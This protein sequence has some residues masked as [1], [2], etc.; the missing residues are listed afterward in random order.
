[1]KGATAYN[2]ANGYWLP[3]PN[4][5]QYSAASGLPI[6]KGFIK[7]EIQT[8]YGNPCGTWKDVTLEVLSYGYAGRNVNPWSGLTAAQYG[9]NEPI[10]GLPGAQV[11]PPTGGSACQDVHPNAIIRLERVRDNPA[12][13]TNTPPTTNSHCGVTNSATPAT[14]MYPTNPADY[15]PNALFD[16]REGTLRDVSPTGSLGGINY[17]QMVTLGGVMQYVELDA[18][19]VG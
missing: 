5:A 12:N 4:V 9:S 14:Q 2:T 16:T 18:K 8:A 3:T 1:M 7:I 17:S 13:W 10:L 6:I 19:N 15:W 11:G